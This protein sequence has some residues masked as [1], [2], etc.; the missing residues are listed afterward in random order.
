VSEPLPQSDTHA[1][2]GC[3][4]S[5]CS[6]GRIDNVDHPSSADGGDRTL[7]SGK[8]DIVALSISG[9]I[10]AK[11]E[12]VT[13]HA[14]MVIQGLF[15][16]RTEKKAKTVEITGNELEAQASAQRA[17]ALMEF[18]KKSH[19][20]IEYMDAAGKG[21]RAVDPHVVPL[22]RQLFDG[23][24]KV[25][26]WVIWRQLNEDT[27][28]WKSLLLTQALSVSGYEEEPTVTR[29]DSVQKLDADMQ[30]SD[31][32][33]PLLGY[34]SEEFVM[35]PA[36]FKDVA[37]AV[38]R[39]PCACW[40]LPE[41]RDTSAP[42]LLTS[43]GGLLT[44]RFQEHTSFIPSSSEATVDLTDTFTLMSAEAHEATNAV[45]GLWDVGCKLRSLAFATAHRV[46]SPFSNEGGLA[47]PLRTIATELALVFTPPPELKQGLMA[48]FLSGVDGKHDREWHYSMPAA[49]KNL[50]HSLESAKLV[51]RQASDINSWQHSFVHDRIAGIA[52]E[53]LSSLIDLCN[54]L[55]RFAQSSTVPHWIQNWRPL[56]IGVHGSLDAEHVLLDR[57][58]TL[59][60]PDLSR[61]DIG[62]PYDDAAQ[63]VASILFEH[64]LAKES[65]RTQTAS[66]ELDS[67][68]AFASAASSAAQSAAQSAASAAVRFALPSGSSRKEGAGSDRV[69]GKPQQD[70]EDTN[71]ADDA[72]MMTMLQHAKVVVNMLVPVNIK[73]PNYWEEAYRSLKPGAPP[74][75][76]VA[77]TLCQNVMRSA[78]NLIVRCGIEELARLRDDNVIGAELSTGD[79]ISFS[80]SSRKVDPSHAS[81]LPDQTSAQ[82]ASLEAPTASVSGSTPGSAARGGFRS[83]VQAM[84]KK[85]SGS[86]GHGL[87]AVA[88][89]AMMK[90]SEHKT[91]EDLSTSGVGGAELF[92]AKRVGARR[93]STKWAEE[94]QAHLKTMLG[95]DVDGPRER[96]T[97]SNEASGGKHAA[98]KAHKHRSF[99]HVEGAP[100]KLASAA[101]VTFGGLERRKSESVRKEGESFLECKESERSTDG[102]SDGK[103]PYS[104]GGSSPRDLSRGN[105]PSIKKRRQTIKSNVER[106]YS[107]IAADCHPVNFQLTLLVLALKAC[108][109]ARFGKWQKALAFYTANRLAQALSIQI[110]RPPETPATLEPERT[111]ES[112][113]AEGQHLLIRD[114]ATWKVAKVEGS[115]GSELTHVWPQSLRSDQPQTSADKVQPKLATASEGTSSGHNS[116][117]DDGHSASGVV[118]HTC[119]S[120]LVAPLRTGYKLEKAMEESDLAIASCIRLGELLEE[121]G[122]HELTQ[123]HALSLLRQADVHPVACHDALLQYLQNRLPR[124]SEPPA[125]NRLNSFIELSARSRTSSSHQQESYFLGVKDI[126]SGIQLQVEKFCKNQLLMTPDIL[127]PRMAPGERLWVCCSGVWKVG[128]VLC[129]PADTGG[130]HKL[131][132][133]GH[134]I[135]S[136]KISARGEVQRAMSL[137]SSEYELELELHPY[138]SAP[139]L[140]NESEMQV[141]QWKHVHYLRTHHAMITSHLTGKR[142]SVFNHVVPLASDQTEQ[143][144]EQWK[145]ALQQLLVKDRFTA[146]RVLAAFKSDSKKKEWNPALASSGGLK[147]LMA[148]VNDNSSQVVGVTSPV[149]QN[150][151]KPT[152]RS[153]S[154]P[155]W[156]LNDAQPV[157]L[158]PL[159]ESVQQSAWKSPPLPP[160]P[161]SSADSSPM[162]SQKKGVSQAA[163]LP[164]SPVSS[165]SKFVPGESL[166]ESGNSWTSTEFKR[167]GSEPINHLPSTSSSK[168]TSLPDTS[169]FLPEED[170]S[171]PTALSTPAVMSNE[172]SPE[173]L[174]TAAR[175]AAADKEAEGANKALKNAVDAAGEAARLLAKVTDVRTLWRWLYSTYVAR[176]QWSPR[177]SAAPPPMGVVVRTGSSGS[178]ALFVSQLVMCA[179]DNVGEEDLAEW[180]HSRSRSSTVTLSE[181]S[182]GGL[183]RLTVADFE[184]LGK[185]SAEVTMRRSVSSEVTRNRGSTGRNSSN[186]GLQGGGERQVLSTDT[187]LA[188]MLSG[189]GDAALEPLAPMLQQTRVPPRIDDVQQPS[190]QWQRKFGSTSVLGQSLVPLPIRGIELARMMQMDGADE[191]FANALNWCEAWAMLVHGSDSGW[192]K[193]LHDCFLARRVLIIL[194]DIDDEADFAPR[195]EEHIVEV[196][197]AQ[198]HP[199]V[200][201]TAQ[202]RAKSP[203]K[204]V[205]FHHLRVRG[206]LTASEQ[207]YTI[208]RNLEG[209]LRGPPSVVV[210]YLHQ[211][212]DQSH[213]S[214]NGPISDHP[215]VLN[216]VM[217]LFEQQKGDIS[218]MPRTLSQLY[219]VATQDIFKRCDR[220]GQW[221]DPTAEA[222]QVSALRT[223]S[224]RAGA[225][226]G[227]PPVLQAL[228]SGDSG[229]TLNLLQGDSPQSAKASTGGLNRQTTI[230]D[231]DKFRVAPFIYALALQVRSS[232]NQRI[233]ADTIDCVLRDKPEFAVVWAAVLELAC[234]DSFPLFSVLR[235][236]PLSIEF[237]HSS[238]TDFLVV[239]SL[240]LTQSLPVHLFV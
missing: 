185:L 213:D 178:K 84:R 33:G 239:E 69:S 52:N 203:L 34:G 210:D 158:S 92:A 232:G 159:P 63:L 10:V 157:N 137:S 38:L 56:S 223:A 16:G 47:G 150:L 64:I 149:L 61:A 105:E 142:T 214:G 140:V 53:D 96:P 195:L 91:L 222:D 119:L 5:K 147:G 68:R 58:G 234:N 62:G 166:P 20:K 130:K 29:I 132:F 12:K 87:A 115:P 83:R 164:S 174:A 123:E 80:S 186:A 194:I 230:D 7:P 72:T 90:P 197:I 65:P 224:R 162:P 4:A 154:S 117:I 113:F 221:A 182:A 226:P 124:I 108:R 233:T 165:K 231:G 138:N 176:T 37:G 103:A 107:D 55:K 135:V 100:H 104:T 39:L 144:L 19:L 189:E 208:A 161:N 50:L 134:D 66:E 74:H 49:L 201:T 109:S 199:L 177:A 27:G 32:W 167:R 236:K 1:S 163:S 216:F 215:I 48:S 193:M 240:R 57:L 25:K 59:W 42:T 106:I 8:S 225:A 24:S 198:A 206:K 120:W 110:E 155:S 212:F 128:T 202:L 211:S 76:R 139:C 143:F 35:G 75:M 205:G 31:I 22:L 181:G 73:L 111:G 121:C 228:K 81:A 114:G 172:P 26:V 28:T 2:M 183:G 44:L 102:G 60:L 219:S 125:L 54:T 9:D 238:L 129:P 131:M 235:K 51:E 188:P 70:Q 229:S 133:K 160:I 175:E 15:K 168:R 101:I 145:S 85:S 173:T 23:C 17:N 127:L 187:K 207:E 67:V 6:G 46:D 89:S 94:S 200:I 151:R 192:F 40:S 93:R 21:M 3:G 11:G 112:R 97:S 43:L 169:K 136:R 156:A 14:A 190:S 146:R 184:E 95:D 88:L 171:R 204:S 13:E 98:P 30:M 237:A 148:K 79:G 36:Y 179:L 71:Y 153:S 116:E 86:G 18:Y 122:E 45:G 196:L 78:A 152:K 227:P 141:M 77:L 180:E 99:E 118:P 82:E 218:K 126:I 220:L 217:S 41:F 209:V 170:T 191:M